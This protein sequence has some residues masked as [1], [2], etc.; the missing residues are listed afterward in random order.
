MNHVAPEPYQQLWSVVDGSVADAL[1]QHPDYLTPKG[2]RSARTSIVKRVTGTVLSFAVQAAKGRPRPAE[3]SEAPSLVSAQSAPLH[4]VQTGE[5]MSPPS[6]HC[7][8]GMIRFKRRTRYRAAHIFDLTTAQ[9]RAEM[10]ER[11]R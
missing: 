7:R 9:L 2:I 8:I 1:K 11:G 3:T 6:P 5:G 4:G 10:K